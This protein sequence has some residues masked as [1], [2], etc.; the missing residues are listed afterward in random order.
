MKTV[1]RIVFLTGVQV[2]AVLLL[3]RVARAASESFPSI[4][5]SV[6]AAVAYGVPAVMTFIMSLWLMRRSSAGFRSRF[7]TCTAAVLIAG[8]GHVMS[9]FILQRTDVWITERY[10]HQMREKLHAEPRF[11]DVRLICYSD[12]YILFPY[13]P[14]AG[15]V[16]TEDDRKELHRILKESHAPAYVTATMVRVGLSSEEL[17][18]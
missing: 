10:I 8:M 3:A 17:S 12:D 9:L 18:R 13:I 6:W 7:L 1:L 5:V 11:K 4:G 14:I 2:M 16:P 15:S